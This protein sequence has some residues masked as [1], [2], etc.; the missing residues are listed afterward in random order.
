M[1]ILKHLVIGLISVAFL[2]GTVVVLTPTN[3]RVRSGASIPDVD[4]SK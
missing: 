1:P 4:I 2:C 3:S